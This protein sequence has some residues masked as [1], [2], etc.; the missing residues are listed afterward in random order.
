MLPITETEPFAPPRETANLLL[1]IAILQLRCGAH[2]ERVNRNVKRFAHALGYE[3]E[4]FFSFSGV[5]LTLQNQQHTI[6]LFRRVETHGIKLSVLVGVSRLSWRALEERLSIDEIREEVYRLKESPAYPFPLIVVL[7]SLACA[8]L[9][10]LFGA[11]ALVMVTTAV[12]TMAALV[13]RQTLQQWG[14]NIFLVIACSAFTAVA[15]SGLGVHL[16][17]GK[18][19]HLAIATSVLFLVPGAPLI[20]AVIDQINGHILVGVARG[21]MGTVIAFAIA[22]GMLVALNMQGLG[23]P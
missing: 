10:R 16:E 8:S 12:A 19:P 2:T 3:P 18:S 23:Q 7:V 4:L 17:I 22:L 6:T 5:T 15:I 14:F 13:T 20:N 11:D 1:D 9:A 21:I